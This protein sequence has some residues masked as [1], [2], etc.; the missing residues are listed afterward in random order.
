[1]PR[2]RTHALAAT[3]VLALLAFGT[4]FA[5]GRARESRSASARTDRTALTAAVPTELSSRIAS[6]D[7]GAEPAASARSEI[8]SASP[9]AVPAPQ[10][11]AP[12]AR[13]LGRVI[14]V[15]GRPIA[16]AL[17]ELDSWPAS[18]RR[19]AGQRGARTGAAGG[20]ELELSLAGLTRAWIEASAG[21]FHQ[22]ARVE[23]DRSQLVAGE[24]RVGD[25]VLEAAGVIRGRVRDPNGAALTGVTVE[26]R[27]L[28][29]SNKPVAVD[30]TG[31]FTI[32]RCRPGPCVVVA[33]GPSGARLAD[34]VT[35]IEPGVETVVELLL[36]ERERTISGIALDRWQRPLA[37]VQVHGV[38]QDWQRDAR[39][40]T[41]QDGSFTLHP[42]MAGRH[43]LVLANEHGQRT[44]P[45]GSAEPGD[46]QLVL[47]DEHGFVLEVEAR[48][49]DTGDALSSF[50][51]VAIALEGLERSGALVD[52]PPTSKDG[53]ARVYVDPRV[54]AILGVADGHLPVATPVLVDAGSLA[55]QT[56]DFHRGARLRGRVRGA[57]HANVVLSADWL[58]NG[59][60]ASDHG[61]MGSK[62]RTDVQGR[63][64][65]SVHTLAD[66]HGSFEL[67]GIAAG[68]YALEVR[69]AYGRYEARG[70]RIEAGQTRDL[71]E[72]ELMADARLEGRI[73]SSGAAAGGWT[74]W[75]RQWSGG[76][77]PVATDGSFLIERMSSGAHELHLNDRRGKLL[78]KFT[79]ELAPGETRR[80]EWTVDGL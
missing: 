36:R 35:S 68:T 57:P 20:F 70:L 76:P 48:D 34:L 59:E 30:E 18:L 78:R 32:A 13:L 33:S 80:V 31:A 21:P 53:R 19:S 6:R 22:R 54:H 50:A 77:V 79:L 72:L 38:P 14:E 60:P 55:R 58:L 23:L 25:V 67:S 12:V 4:W 44:A 75:F 27:A 64:R 45:V 62:A 39:T 8:E 46:T 73:S 24:H 71:G 74:I 56:L 11:V 43:A 37:G 29:A 1:M 61:Y 9:A 40:T 51:A 66:E 7:S 49:A 10:P 65:P 69:A 2:A 41:A 42:R 15:D 17:V 16:E 5:F 26:A 63:H 28:I 3:L 47:V 52:R